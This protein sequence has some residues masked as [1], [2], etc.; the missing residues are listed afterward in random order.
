MDHVFKKRTLGDLKDQVAAL[1]VYDI[2]IRLHSHC[3]L[4]DR[5]GIWP[6]KEL[7]FGLLMVTIWLELCMSYSSICHHH[8][9]HPASTKSRMETFWYRLTQFHLENGC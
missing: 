3:W 9:H 4:G 2:Q 7:D 1:Y 8:L 6:V 5:K